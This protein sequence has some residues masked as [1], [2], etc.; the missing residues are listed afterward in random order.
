MRNGVWPLVIPVY[1]YSYT[2]QDSPEPLG[3]V[4]NPGDYQI[5]H[6][7]RIIWLAPG[8]MPPRRGHAIALAV[9]Q[10]WVEC[11]DLAPSVG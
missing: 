2:L 5:D 9:S 10:A 6:E 4:D 1:C 3:D 7:D 8:L 11:A